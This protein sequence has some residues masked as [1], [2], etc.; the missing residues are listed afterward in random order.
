MIEA[1]GIVFGGVSRLVQFGME[2]K[3]KQKERDHEHRMLEK[4]TELQDKRLVHDADMRRM[5]NVAQADLAELNALTSAVEAQS[6]EA[7][8][9]GGWVTKLS[10]SIRPLLTVYHA[11][12]VYTAVKLATFFVAT[13]G[14]L[15]WS[16]ATLS[17]YGEFDRALLGSMV[18]FWFS[19]RSLRN[20]K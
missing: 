17:I 5:D 12:F 7:V 2:L 4:Q 20:Q 19:D 1:L 3:D 10:A 14:G 16:E 13:Q 15:S 9:A 6:R 18:G 8:Y 11:V